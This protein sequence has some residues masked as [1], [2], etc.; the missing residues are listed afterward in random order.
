MANLVEW[1]NSNI[2]ANPWPLLVATEFV[3]RFLA[4]HPFQ[5]GNG[6]LGRA[7]FILILFQSKDKYLEAVIPY[8][9]IDRHIEQH[10]SLYY[11]TLRQCSQ[12]KYH[13]EP[14]KY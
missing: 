7:L 13:Q 2:H 1:Y 3:S 14:E 12:G 10:R 4:I 6:R 8:I 11:T 9:A 5:D